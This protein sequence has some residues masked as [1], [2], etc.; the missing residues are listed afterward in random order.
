MKRGGECMPKMHNYYENLLNTH[1]YN[2]HL[3]MCNE[4]GISLEDLYTNELD[5]NDF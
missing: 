2:N 5:E 4:L 3:E 1:H